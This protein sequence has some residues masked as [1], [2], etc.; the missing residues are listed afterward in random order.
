MKQMKV[1]G[2]RAI[3]FGAL[4]AGSIPANQG[5]MWTSCGEVDGS[6]FVSRT[7]GECGLGP[8]GVVLCD[9]SISFGD[10]QF[11]WQHSDYGVSG[12]Y[13]CNGGEITGHGFNQTYSGRYDRSSDILTWE[14]VEYARQ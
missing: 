2:L 1:L 4:A 10:G 8:D 9:W 12:S 13:E 14:G 6:E 5:C 11:M 7:Q 3:I